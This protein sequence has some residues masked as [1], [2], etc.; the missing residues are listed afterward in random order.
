M[1]DVT[2]APPDVE[3]VR[4]LER[5]LARERATRLET[6]R[7]AEAALRRLYE[8][9]ELKTVLLGTVNHEL[10]TPATI[11]AGFAE[12]LT[13][14]WDDLDDAERRRLLGRI[15]HNARGLVA[16]VEQV[17]ELA[18]LEVETITK[19]AEPLALAPWLRQFAEEPPDAA[20]TH[21]VVVEADP[22]LALLVNPVALRQVVENLVANARR[23]A[24]AGTDITLRAT[25]CDQEVVVAVADAGPGVPVEERSRIFEPFYRGDGEHVAGTSGFGIGLSVVRRLMALLGGEVDVDDAPQGGAEFR[26]RWPVTMLA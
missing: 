7:I 1:D 20:G 2:P 24:P 9:D 15:H 10:R 23:Y 14:N 8:A 17:L 26:L 21:V 25:V 22:G 3:H 16:L 5:R 18:R 13:A 6:E 11:I 12:H 4:R 19:V